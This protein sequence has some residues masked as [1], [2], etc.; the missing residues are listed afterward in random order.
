MAEEIPTI[1]ATEHKWPSRVP[2]LFSYPGTVTAGVESP[3][4]YLSEGYTFTTV[5]LSRL[6]AGASSVAVQIKV[7]GTTIHTITLTAGLTTL[8]EAVTGGEYTIPAD[9]PVTVRVS[10]AGDGANLSVVLT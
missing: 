5:R 8:V 7:G 3:P 2:P 1:F 10:S 9:T 6:A 4:L